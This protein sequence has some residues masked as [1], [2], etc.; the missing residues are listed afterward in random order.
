MVV[1][2]LL[3]LHPVDSRLRGNDG[4][5]T[6]MTA[7]RHRAFWI[8]NQVRTMSFRFQCNAERNLIAKP[9]NLLNCRNDWNFLTRCNV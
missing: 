5:G 1:V 8:A 9:V 3:L 4:R 7:A 2:V 6:G